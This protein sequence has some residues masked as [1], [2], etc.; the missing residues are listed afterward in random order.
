MRVINFMEL[1]ACSSCSLSDYFT[2]VKSDVLSPKK[3]LQVASA[4]SKKTRQSSSS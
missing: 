3:K 4:L 1:Q 2:S